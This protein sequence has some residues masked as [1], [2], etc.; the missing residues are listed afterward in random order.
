MNV[1]AIVAALQWI[2]LGYFVVLNAVYLALNVIALFA[3]R[4]Y[5][6]QRVADVGPALSPE[7]D[8]PISVIVP[9]YNESLTIGESVRALLQ[10]EYP[11][12][13]IV[14]VNDGS[15]DATLETLIREFSLRPFPEAYRVRLPSK[16]VEGIYRSTIYPQLRV[17]DKANGGKADSI[18]AGIN[19]ARYPIFCVIDA[20]SVLQRDSLRRAIQPFLDDAATVAAG[21]TIRIANGCR[22]SGGFM[23]EIDLPRHPLAVFQIVEYL[24]AFLF[25]RLGWSPMNALLI[26]SG[27]FGLFRK[28]VVVAAGG[29]RA[30]TIGE[31]MELIVR[32]HRVLRA[33]GRRY[34]ICYVPDPICWTEAPEDLRTL[35]RQR[36]RWQRGLIE[37]L[38]LNASLCFNPRAGAVG[39]VAFPF[40]LVFECLGP[41]IEVI[42]LAAL[43]F[44][45]IAGYLS[46]EAFLVLTGLS[47]VLGILLSTSAFVF[48][49]M[50]FHVYPRLGQTLRLFLFAVLENFGYRQLNSIW[51]MYGVFLHLRGKPAKWGEMTR[52]GSWRRS[53]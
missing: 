50:S 49:Q 11:H 46:V 9:A 23:E 36:I 2:F 25:G 34:R 18:N 7:L 41:I 35:G 44:A 27:A 15:K 48:E 28:E 6:G 1:A 20:D 12:F 32:M 10:L 31:D 40:F 38:K 5:M 19:A 52:L 22:V 43:L 33:E 8:L 51:R 13:E 21:G 47:I 26:I 42:G 45:A 30:D 37:S 3:L 39:M 17:I 14:V 24:R 16:P 53:P 29:F 4:R